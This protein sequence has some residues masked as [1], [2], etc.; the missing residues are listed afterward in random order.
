MRGREEATEPTLIKQKCV[1]NG[2]HE[3]AR[4]A[5]MYVHA[6]CTHLHVRVHEFCSFSQQVETTPMSR[7]IF[8]GGFN[9][10]QFSMLLVRYL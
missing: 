1:V 2:A 3:P 5:G 8:W 4:Q 10:S 7:T 6:R 9:K